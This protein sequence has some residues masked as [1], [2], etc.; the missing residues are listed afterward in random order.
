MPGFLQD[1][2]GL[3]KRV[4]VDTTILS[5][6][7]ARR[8]RDLVRA[9]HQEL[10]WEWWETRKDR[11]DVYASDLVESEA[12]GGNPEAAAR[13]LELLEGV[14]LLAAGQEAKALSALLME[15]GG[16]PEEAADDAVHLA[17]ATVHGMDVLLTWN[18]GHLANP[19]LR[20][21]LADRIRAAGYKPPVVCTPEELLEEWP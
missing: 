14:P 3:R 5:Y 7:A 19:V 9:A 18:R 15:P 10:T 4:Y 2:E 11:S 20:E 21:V 6:L 16:L 8:S 12:G 17:L 1:G 13:R